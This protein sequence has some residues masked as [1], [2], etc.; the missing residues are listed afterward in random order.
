[1][2]D[3]ELRANIRW[4]ELQCI[5]EQIERLS[6]SEK[7]FDKRLVLILQHKREYVRPLAKKPE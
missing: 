4:F 3:P 7:E 6:K 1:M 2:K 5:E